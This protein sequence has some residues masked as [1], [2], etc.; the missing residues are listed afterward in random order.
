MSHYKKYSVIGGSG[1]LGTS[2][3]KKF[4]KNEISF[5]IIDIKKSNLY[6]ERTKIVDVRDL[7]SLS[8]A[9]TGDII[10]NLAAVHRDDV[11][12][13]DEYYSTNVEGAKNIIQVCNEKNIKKIV[14]T[15]T[16][17]VYGFSN[18]PVSESGKTK[19]FN[20]YGK[21]KLM[22]EKLFKEWNKKSNTSLTIIRPTVIF[23]EGNRG[24][25]FNLFN[26]IN[27]GKFI[28]IGSGKNKKSMAYIENVSSFIES[29]IIDESDFSLFNYTDQPDMDMNTLVNIIRKTLKGKSTI[30]LR[31]PYAVGMF[32]GYLAD[33]ASLI[34]SKKLPISSIRIK[35]FCKS[36]V[37]LSN[38]KNLHNFRAPYSLTEGIEKTLINEFINPDPNREIFYTE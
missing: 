16:V 30:G 15:S 17:A 18:I 2:L 34:F 23:G 8:A 4:N 25:V 37:F 1:F 12:N 22:A 28:M 5:E 26:Q 27:S 7:K 35:K 32:F 31:L 11:S 9:I 36:S 14:F 29:C 24:N 13:I 3:C 10:I 19:P 6:P 21:S 33:I 20:H 38:T